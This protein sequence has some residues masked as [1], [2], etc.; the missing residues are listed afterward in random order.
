MKLLKKYKENKKR[1]TFWQNLKDVFYHLHSGK[2]TYIYWLSVIAINYILLG[3]H[4][5]LEMWIFALSSEYA[6]GKI[7]DR[8]TDEQGS[9]F[10]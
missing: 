1:M 9:D 2:K 7:V 3:K 8:Y 10:L 6:I 5:P 4:L